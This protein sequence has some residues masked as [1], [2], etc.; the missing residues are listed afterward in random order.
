ML[1]AVFASLLVALSFLPPAARSHPSASVKNLQGLTPR[2]VDFTTMRS[3]R[4]ALAIGGVNTTLV[5]EIGSWL[6]TLNA[7]GKWPDS[8]VN[9]ATGCDGRRANWP[10]EEH[11]VR[12]ETLAAA[13][14]GGLPGADAYVNSSAV[15]STASRAMDFWF[16]NDMPN[17]DCL[18]NG[19]TGNCP[20]GTPGFW[21]TNWFPNLIGVPVLVGDTCLILGNNTLSDTQFG[22][23][24]NILERTFGTFASDEWFITGANILDMAKC[25]ITAALLAENT[26]GLADAYGHVHSEVVVQDATFA[27]GIRPDGS[28]GQHTGIIYNGNYGKDYSN[29]VIALEIT[30]GGTEFAAGDDSKSAFETLM[31]GNLWMIYKNIKTGILHWDFSVTGRMIT[32]AVSDEQATSSILINTTLLA[33]LGQLWGSDTISSAASQLTSDTDNAN[34]GS[35]KGNR[36]FYDNDYMVHRGDGYVTTLRMYSSR[37]ANTECV[38]NQNTVGFHL[39][40]GTVYTYLEGDEY[41]DIAGMWDWNLIPGTTTDYGNTPL[42]CNHTEAIG[43]EAFVGGASDGTIGAAAMRYTNP[44]TGALSFQKAWFFLDDDV[45]H[46]MLSS[47]SSASSAPVFSVLDQKR[48]SGPVLLDGTPL[49]HGGNFTHARTL[50]HDGVGY[51]F[52]PT[53]AP[54]SVDWGTRTGNWGAVGISAAGVQSADLFSAWVAS[55]APA[56][57]EYSIFPATSAD[58][59]RAKAAKTAVTLATVR[60]DAQVSAVYDGAHHVAAAVFWDAAGGNVTFAAR[61]PARAP[62][63]VSVQEGAIVVYRLDEGKITVADPTQTLSSVEVTLEVVGQGEKPAGFGSK[64]RVVV[65]VA[66]PSGGSAGKSVTTS[67]LDVA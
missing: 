4:A 61:E 45:Q 49:A 28:F 2:D 51:A 34:V 7:E 35:V 26:T 1:L 56:D 65:S 58:A 32:F 38:N 64:T 12:I 67:L 33:E 52:A 15:L 16:A 24:T 59:F 21:N 47:L 63:A 18:Y 3:R 57:T 37:T 53:G 30:A 60:N 31:D 17:L 14:R 43:K 8:E 29:D 13:W 40:D 11:W 5:P 54:V 23:C 25:G 50:W 20:C 48:H 42:D 66:L 19:G 39:A 10:A 41:E 36:M 46:V 9:Y 22:N 62:V 55:A 27:D 6:D 44:L